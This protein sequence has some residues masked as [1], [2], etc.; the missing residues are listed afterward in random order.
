MHFA[1]IGDPASASKM[2]GSFTPRLRRSVQD[3][4][5][6]FGHAPSSCHQFCAPP[7]S[8]ARLTSAT[9][10]P[11]RV[12]FDWGASRTM[13]IPRRSVQVCLP[14][15]VV[16]LF[17]S[18]VIARDKH[19]KTSTSS[20]MDAHQRTRHA[21]NRLTFG[22]RPG[23]VERVERIGV[24]AWVEQ[25]L[26]P[27]KI[28]DTALETRLSPLR[29]LR[30][31]TREMLEDFPPQPVVKAVMDGK[32]PM[33]SDPARRAIYEAQIERLRD[34]EERKQTTTAQLDPASTDSEGPQAADQA[35]RPAARDADREQRRQE[36]LFASQR[37]EI[38]LKL[39][40]DQR[41]Q[42]ILHMNPQDRQIVAQHMPVD[43]RLRLIA[44]LKPEQREVV[45]A[46]ANPKAV[47]QDE[48]M[49]GKLI[50]AIYS[51]RQ[52]EQVMTD[53][54]FNHFNVF[55]GKGADRYLITAYEREVI[56]PHVLGKFKDLL[57]A[58]AK[59]PAMLFYLDNW[60][61]VGPDSDFARDA[62][63]RQARP[64]RI[65]RRRPW[66]PPIIVMRGRP[67]R[68]SAAQRRGRKNQTGLNENY[69]RELMELH[70]L[71][72]NGGYTQQDVT[73][74]ARVFTGWTLREPRKGGEFDFDQRK[75]EPGTK[76]VLG[77]KIKE[78]GEKEG[79]EVLHLLAKHPATARFICTK[80]AQRFV[81]DDPP[82][83]LIDRMSKTF[84]DKDGDIREVLRTMFRSPEFWSP[85]VYRA[86]VKTP[87]EFV[88][89]A[90]RA[91]GVDVS[92]ALPLIQALNRMG[93]PPYGAQPPSGYKN[94]AE[95]WVN[96]AALLNRMNFA[97]ALAAGKL[98][99]MKSFAGTLLATAPPS[100]SPQLPV[101]ADTAIAQLEIAL[102]AGE[103][104]QNT[105]DTIRKQLN[106]GPAGESDRAVNVPLIAGLI[107]GSPEF[108]R[109]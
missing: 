40:P 25:Q 68:T 14:I 77:H 73:E 84:L 16:A 49:E 99:G 55:I 87:L 82:Q 83:A 6:K 106:D 64:A 96:S 50:R 1:G 80:L 71:G 91:S 30:M 60:M 34:R 75:H 67:D 39:P 89:S 23:E 12:Q 58:T 103:L 66:G 104:S 85:D 41:Y 7:E 2:H 29:T 11:P 62:P 17:A 48:L 59:S 92:T 10:T 24:D 45:L 36:R 105:H 93:M 18:V 63:G 90:V 97:L 27:E 8:I 32:L 98:P 108:Q 38:L 46:L 26:H 101:D 56:R 70:T 43:Q 21:L 72:V 94:D 61:S 22:P 76:H 31:S 69:A 95:T 86:K 15:I 81:S 88:V 109:R 42:E 3:D 4:G 52:L 33:P 53:F 47:V 5:A 74:V 13:Y 20:Q 107:L 19:S 54:W 100:A 57:S 102:L 79:D 28:D 51:E 78:H 65:F 35:A 9:F 37:A 44:D